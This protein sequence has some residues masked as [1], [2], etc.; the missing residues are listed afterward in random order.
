MYKT[1]MGRLYLDAS[2]AA[3]LAAPRGLSAVYHLL[4]YAAT[5]GGQQLSETDNKDLEIF[6]PVSVRNLHSNQG[7]VWQLRRT[8]YSVSPVTYKAS[9]VD[10]G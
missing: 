3:H 8:V 9:T 1:G 7:A 5:T 2:C 10:N 6:L 4:L